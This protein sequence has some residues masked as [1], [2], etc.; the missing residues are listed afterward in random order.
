MPAVLVRLVHLHGSVFI[1]ERL[2][3]LS[4]PSSVE[5]TAG[6][7]VRFAGNERQGESRTYRQQFERSFVHGKISAGREISFK[8]FVVEARRG[9]RGIFVLTADNTQLAMAGILL[10]N[11]PDAGPV[12]HEN[13]IQWARVRERG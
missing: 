6:R 9:E 2:L 11:L 4:E 7:L 13:S 12:Q 3:F 10:A 5:T 8:S 1:K